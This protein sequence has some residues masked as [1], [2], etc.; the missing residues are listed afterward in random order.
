V[1]R[2]SVVGLIPLLMHIPHVR[3]QVT[4]WYHQPLSTCALAAWSLAI[5]AFMPVTR[6]PV[7][8]T[9]ACALAAHDC[10][11]PMS[12]LGGGGRGGVVMMMMMMVTRRR[13]RRR[14][15]REDGDQE[16]D[17]A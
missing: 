17:D 12:H 13:R 5:V 15:R 9:S 2:S 1:T 7:V 11:E 6:S 16:D 3:H 10:T 4:S 14:R 8:A